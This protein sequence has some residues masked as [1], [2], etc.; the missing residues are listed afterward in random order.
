MPGWQGS[1]WERTGS[2]RR[3]REKPRLNANLFQ[4]VKAKA[5]A[6]LL[7]IGGRL[8]NGA[9]LGRFVEG[10]TDVAER[11]C[12]VV[13]FSRAEQCEILS[14]QRMEPRLD[15]AI[16]NAFAGAVPHAAFG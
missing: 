13:L 10:R 11:L 2:P 4:R 3:L 15:A 9:S 14:L 12:G 6:G 16:V 7:A 5:E 1:S 8:V